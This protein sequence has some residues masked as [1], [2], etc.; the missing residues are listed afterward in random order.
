MTTTTRKVTR[1]LVTKIL[2]EA[3]FAKAEWRNRS[4]EKLWND[5]FLVSTYDLTIAGVTTKRVE[6]NYALVHSTD[7]DKPA[8]DAMTRRM[9]GALEL[10]GIETELLDDDH[11]FNTIRIST[12]ESN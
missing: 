11:F 5:G 9:M 1:P 8:I 6:I 4:T 10:A 3:G 2:V 7:R 12:K